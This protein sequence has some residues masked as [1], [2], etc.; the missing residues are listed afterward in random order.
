MVAFWPQGRDDF[1]YERDLGFDGVILE[2]S[3]TALDAF[4]GSCKSID[5]VGTRLHGGI[6]CLKAGARCLILTI[7]NRARS[8]SHDTGLPTAARGD[9][10]ALE[11]WIEGAPAPNLLLPERAINMWRGQFQHFSPAG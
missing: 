9:H 8:I 4:L 1:D 7:D 10:R 3:L 5:Y 6:R 2:R 11:R